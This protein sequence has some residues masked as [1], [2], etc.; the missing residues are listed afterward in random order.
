MHLS[1]V[2]NDDNITIVKSL[3]KQIGTPLEW[4]EDHEQL[5]HGDLGTQEQHMATMESHALESSAHEWL[6]YLITIPGIF[7]IQMAAVDAIWRIYICEKSLCAIP[8]GIYDQFKILQPKDSSKLVTAPTYHMLNDGIIHLVHS[9]ILVCW[10]EVVGGN[11]QHM[12]I[13]H[14]HGKRL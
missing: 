10:E 11:I 5:C 7:H 1:A 8:G 13:Q 4:F 9:H 12:W 6:Q 2:S 3:E 14:Y